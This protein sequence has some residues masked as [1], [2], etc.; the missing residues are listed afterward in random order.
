M[1]PE[2]NFHVIRGKLAA[3]ILLIFGHLILPGCNHDP[4]TSVLALFIFNSR[5]TNDFNCRVFFHF[6]FVSSH[7][8]GWYL[9]F[10]NLR[11]QR[12]I[13]DCVRSYDHYFFISYSNPLGMASMYVY[14]ISSRYKYDMVRHYIRPETKPVTSF[15]PWRRECSVIPIILAYSSLHYRLYHSC[16]HPI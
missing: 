14:N 13:D 3:T 7:L 8:N 9:D 1:Q 5:F 4:A 6:R 10:S 15:F 16:I 11:K 2:F 12:D